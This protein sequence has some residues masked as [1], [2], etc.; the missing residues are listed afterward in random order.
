MLACAQGAAKSTEAAKKDRGKQTP[1]QG[2]VDQDSQFRRLES[3]TWN[4]VTD[5]LTWVVSSGDERNGSYQPGKKETYSIHM[6]SATMKFGAE[7]RLFSREEAANV[8]V[9]MDLL[10]KYAIDSTEWWE[11]GHGQKLDDKGNPMPGKREEEH[12]TN[13][14][15]G[16]R[17]TARSGQDVSPLAT[18]LVAD[19]AS[20]R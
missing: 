10:S 6:D 2:N 19:F 5:E 4:P 18:T 12:Q 9:L 20:G 16:V 13:Q 1:Q 15:P 14:A 8:H 3:L 11:E 17:R 7:G